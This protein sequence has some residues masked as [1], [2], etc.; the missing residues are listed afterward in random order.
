MR[1][2][3]QPNLRLSIKG[4]TYQINNDWKFTTDNPHQPLLQ[5]Y[6]MKKELELGTKDE[7]IVLM[8]KQVSKHMANQNIDYTNNDD[9]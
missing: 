3:T 1:V 6:S 2:K 7:M 5:I 4:R 8:G 9:D